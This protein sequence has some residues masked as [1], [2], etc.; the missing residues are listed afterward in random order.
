MNN[1]DWR[2][3][4]K[5]DEDLVRFIRNM[6]KF[7]Q[8]FCDMVIEKKEFTLRLEVKGKKGRLVHCRVGTD[9][10]DRGEKEK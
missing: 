5:D 7:N 3:L 6:E 2:E 1:P 10:F 9:E 8:L 4:L